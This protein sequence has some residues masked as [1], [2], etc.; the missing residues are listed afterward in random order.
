MEAEDVDEQP[1]VRH[2]SRRIA[3]DD[4]ELANFVQ[5]PPLSPHGNDRGSR[6]PNGDAFHEVLIITAYLFLD[7]I[8][9]LSS[10]KYILFSFHFTSG[11]AYLLKSMM[12][13]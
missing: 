3:S 4:I 9:C 10:I 6:Q 11:A 13:L 8:C 1:L 12:R 2:R 7:I 5:S